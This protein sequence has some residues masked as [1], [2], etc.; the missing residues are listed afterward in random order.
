MVNIIPAKHL[1]LSV[2]NFEKLHFVSV[3]CNKLK[4]WDKKLEKGIYGI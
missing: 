3:Q 1:F 4:M 2:T